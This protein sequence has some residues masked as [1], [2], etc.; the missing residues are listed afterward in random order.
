MKYLTATIILWALSLATAPSHADEATT[1]YSKGSAALVRQESADGSTDGNDARFVG[2]VRLEGK[3]VVEFE[4]L[5][6]Q[7]NPEDTVGEAFFVPDAR[8][9]KQLPAAIGRYY[10]RPVD[11]I[12]LD[13]KPG[14][15][16]TQLVGRP[17]TEQILQGRMPRYEVPATLT[18][19]SFSS[20]IACDRRGYTA[21]VASIAGTRPHA[22]AEQEAQ[23]LSC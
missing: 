15:L 20:W 21:E 22:V 12:A 13:K 2:R 16:L 7:Q 1:H 6:N 10:P 5:P 11:F 23:F 4:R 8:S 18:I 3:L 19:Q 9:R 17:Q 14:E